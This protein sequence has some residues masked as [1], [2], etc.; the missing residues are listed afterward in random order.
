M[1]ERRATFTEPDVARSLRE[2]ALARWRSAPDVGR[3]HALDALVATLRNRSGGDTVR[4]AMTRRYAGELLDA[5]DDLRTRLESAEAE[6]A[7]YRRT[8]LSDRATTPTT[9]RR[10]GHRMT[11]KRAEA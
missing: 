2:A 5:I 3:R 6:L 1:T 4:L 9:P 10:K 11:A 7:A 8:A